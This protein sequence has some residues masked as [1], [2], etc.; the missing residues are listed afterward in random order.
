M[1][2]IL[3]LRNV[4]AYQRKVRRGG[5]HAPDWPLDDLLYLSIPTLAI[6]NLDYDDDGGDATYWA[7]S[8]KG[9]KHSKLAI[10]VAGTILKQWQAFRPHPSDRLLKRIGARMPNVISRFQNKIRRLK[11]RTVRDVP[12]RGT[13]FNVVLLEMA[14]AVAELSVLKN[15]PNPMVGSKLLHFLIPEFFPVWDTYWIRRV[16]LRHH[17]DRYQ[18]ITSEVAERLTHL[19]NTKGEVFYRAAREYAS[20]VNLMLRDLSKTS[21]REL[22]SM[23]KECLRLGQMEREVVKGH[24]QNEDLSPMLFEICLLGKYCK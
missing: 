11:I 12:T 17:R 19:R 16:A 7:L 10:S 20:Y 2:E 23:V 21:N 18:S 14:T 24:F 6:R 1:G 5:R 13:K 8:W 3:N 15:A 22:K 9:K 4:R